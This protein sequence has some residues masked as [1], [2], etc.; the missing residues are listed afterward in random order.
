MAATQ[1]VVWTAIP[2]GIRVDG[3]SA[4]K[5]R[6]AVHASLRANGDGLTLNSYP[7]FLHWATQ[8]AVVGFDLTLNLPGAQTKPTT[9]VSAAPVTV[10]WDSLF[11]SNMKVHDRTQA[12]DYANHRVISY[13]VRHIHDYLRDMHVNAA[14]SSGE[15]FVGL[16][17]WFENYTGDLGYGHDNQ[18]DLQR[19]LLNLDSERGQDVNGKPKR[20]NDFPAGDHQKAF[21]ALREF[22]APRQISPDDEASQQPIELPVFDFH[23]ALSLIGEHAPMMRLLGLA[24]DLEVA[25]SDF[26]GITAGGQ[27]AINTTGTSTTGNFGKISVGTALSNTTI[28]SPFSLLVSFGNHLTADQSFTAL[29]SGVVQSLG[30]GGITLDFNPAVSGPANINYTTDW[31]SF[32]DPLSGRSGQLRTTANGTFIPSGGQGEIAG[33]I[34]VASVTP[35]PASMMLLGTGLFGLVGVTRRRRKQQVSLT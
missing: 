12:R 7:A 2:N 1:Q 22:H 3:S 11:P 21:A 34:E 27:L 5:L 15:D 24:F 8:A 31:Q 6:I 9:R 26:T 13:P 10:I 20:Y 33:L 18:K 17:E 23:Q 35:E 14:V 16:L 28:S 30:T 4:D 29:I 19:L 25:V 32:F